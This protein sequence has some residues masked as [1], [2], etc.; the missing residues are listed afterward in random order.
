VAAV[1]QRNLF[2]DRESESAATRSAPVAEPIPFVAA[3][4]LLYPR[5]VVEDVELHTVALAYGG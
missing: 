4:L 2:D 5:P 1:G 3:Q